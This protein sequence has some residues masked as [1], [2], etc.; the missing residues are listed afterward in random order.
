MGNRI[1]ENPENIT[2]SE[3]NVE[4]SHSLILYNDDYNEFGFVIECL[5]DICN[6]NTIQAEQCTLIAHYNGKCEVKVGG[7]DTLNVMRRELT[8]KGLG[9]EV[10]SNN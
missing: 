9:A 3:T 5:I 2:N 7:F 4:R 8:D 10:V 6:H 1:F